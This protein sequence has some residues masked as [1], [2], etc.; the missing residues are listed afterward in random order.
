M[1]A[2][3]NTSGNASFLKKP[4]KLFKF[5]LKLFKFLLKKLSCSPSTRKSW[6]QIGGAL[7]I[8]VL[9]FCTIAV[10]E[11]E[12]KENKPQIT[13]QPPSQTKTD[14]LTPNDSPNN[15]STQPA[16]PEAKESKDQKCE[17]KKLLNFSTLISTL[18]CLTSD[19]K[20]LAQAQNIAVISAASLFFLDTFDRK[21]QL[22]RQAWQL[23]DGAQGSETSGARRQAIEELYEEGSD[24]TG[25]DADGADLRGINLSNAN[26]E[27]ASFKN[28]ILEEANFQGAILR[29]ANFT[30][31]NLKGADFK[32]AK[33]WGA[34][35]TG[36]DLTNFC[37]SKTDLSP[38]ID[39][40]T[41]LRDADLGNTIFNRAKLSGAIF[42]VKNFEPDLGK[43][44]NLNG[45]KLRGANLNNV[46]LNEV[47]IAEAKF[48]G[49]KIDIDTIRKAGKYQEAHYSEDFCDAHNYEFKNKDIPYYGDIEFLQ[50]I[51]KKIVEISQ[52][53]LKKESLSLQDEES[54]SDF[55]NLL[56]YLVI[57]VKESNNQCL[58]DNELS[59]KLI[60]VQKAFEEKQ[61]VEQVVLKIIPEYEKKLAEYEKKL[62]DNEKELTD[63]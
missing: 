22:E 16:N 15:T 45:A 4:L 28:A 7:L 2:P 55:V 35:F 39:K 60:D 1:A 53:L 62:A 11:N 43:K 33:L 18:I 14:K 50:S 20:L 5:L 49:A 46:N 38:A 13:S 29:E 56:N 61:Q 48:G 42:G 41:D 26:L 21:K 10:L 30:G 47:S 9:I 27:R 3:Q 25:L 51:T 63:N 24:I 36:A 37:K 8:T 19:L 54:I 44:T 59:D 31:A 34:D 12:Q 6:L 23:I 40:Q 58:A 57:L 32:K 17:Y 52:R